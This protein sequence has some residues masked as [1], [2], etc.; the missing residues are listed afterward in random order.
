MT[1]VF[2]TTFVAYAVAAETS[3]Q[4]EKQMAKEFLVRNM[5]GCYTFTSNNLTHYYSYL[6]DVFS[7]PNELSNN[8]YRA[9]YAKALHAYPFVMSE[10]DTLYDTQR[11]TEEYLQENINDAYSMWK[12][13]S[14]HISFDT[15]C[16]YILPYRISCEPL[17]NWRRK[18]RE[19]YSSSM[20][21]YPAR[22][23]NY[24][25]VFGMY[26]KLNTG[27]NAAVYYPTGSLPEFSLSDLLIVKL[28]NCESYSARSVAQL[29]AFGIPSTVD[30]VPQW[31][32]R[33]MG[34]SWAV[35]FISD[36]YTLPFGINETL[37]THFMERSELTMPKVYRKT[38]AKQVWLKDISVDV[39]PY[40]P[41]LFRDTRYIDV[42]E[43]Y[44]N[45][46]GVT[47]KIENSEWLE[48]VK[49]VYLG[50]FN[51]KKWVPV[52]FSRI[53][54]N[55]EAEFKA[56]GRGVVYVPFYYDKYGR[57]QYASTPFLLDEEGN[58]RKFIANTENTEKVAQPTNPVGKLYGR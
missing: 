58:V 31:G 32:N 39:S 6:H 53:N 30:F 5:Q 29:R 57:Q 38:L 20:P 36:D 33:S 45:T 21:T 24:Y 56:M 10:C 12:K 51:N 43:K 26:S 16:N 27:F 28:G 4:T 41:S 54:K 23:Y 52:V 3:E 9:T 22:Q 8:Q 48:G 34:H 46:S 50:V 40:V 55:K 2:L 1:I 17:S 13:N 15:F 18:Y 7:S 19:F 47:V 25:H 14:P 35:M 11:V 44:V 49:W 37:G 42:T